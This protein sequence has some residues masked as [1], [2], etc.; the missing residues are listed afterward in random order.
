MKNLY[1]KSNVKKIDITIDTIASD[2]SISHRGAI[3]S[4]LCEGE[5]VITN[6]L[7]GE[8]TLNTLKIIELLGSNIRIDGS[9]IYI[10]SPKIINEP[11]NVLECGNSGTA[12]RLITGLLAGINNGIF[13]LN[14][15]ESIRRRPMKRIIEPLNNNG[16]NIL[17]RNNNTLA[18]IVVSGVKANGFDY[19]M[20]ISSA[21]VKSAMILY[22][23]FAKSSS[24]IEEEY[25][26]RN[27]TE[28]MLFNMG[29]D[30]RT[31]EKGDGQIVTI[32]PLASK[33]KPFNLTVPSDP[34][35]GFFF[36]VAACMVK[37]SKVVL[38]NILFNQTRIEAYR[39]L[40]KMG[41]NIE[42]ISKNKDM[43]EMGDIIITY[44]PLKAISIDSNI[45]WLID[46]IPALSIA[47]CIADGISKIRNAKELRHKESDRIKSVV[48]NLKICNIDVTE[49][50]DGFDV[51]GKSIDSFFKEEEK[52]KINSY[53]DHRVAM[54]FTIFSL[55]K[56]I[57]ILDVD[58]IDTSFP[59]FISLFKEL[60]CEN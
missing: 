49:Y 55:I 56:N 60:C 19:V 48:D 41:A 15:D 36:A 54:S 37:N 14:G 22:A 57:E 27:H 1:I 17:G 35:S 18:P 29:V 3:F 40:Q 53:K 10:T 28:I 32:S 9:T 13:I 46:E 30:I 5:C 4:L 2:K 51:F 50:D 8:D 24:T 6:Y 21:Q 7:L 31:K 33:L 52:I 47:F 11:S 26:S 59:N 23:L 42:F 38:K 34:S 45:A 43:E 25:L 44:A 39:I 58:C 20:N 12:I 16:A